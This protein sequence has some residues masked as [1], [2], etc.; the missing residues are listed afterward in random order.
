[1]KMDWE[2]VV[3]RLQTFPSGTHQILSPCND[4]RIMTIERQLGELPVVLR[5]MVRNFNGAE[6]FINAIPL[7]TLFGI[8]P[9]TPASSLEWSPD[10]YIDKYT[11]KWRSAGDRLGDW[12]IAMTNY[13]GLIVLDSNGNTREWDTDQNG[14]IPSVSHLDARIEEVLSQGD[15]YMQE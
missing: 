11:A 13:G 8:S 15:A 6:L 4:E 9:E 1:M 12:A 10:W 14:W 7:I 3:R 5:E 2:N